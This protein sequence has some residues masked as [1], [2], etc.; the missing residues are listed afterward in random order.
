[1]GCPRSGTT[2]LQLMLHAHPRIAVPPEN[3]FMLPAYSKRRLLGDLREP[4]NKRKLAAQIIGGKG[5]ASTQF[6]DL[7]LDPGEITDAIVAAP[8]TVGSALGTVFRAYAARF[9]KPRWGDKRPAYHH[10]LPFLRRMFPDAQFV[11][12]VRD[13]RACV[14]SL[15]RM[16]WWE[17]DMYTAVAEWAVAFDNCQRFAKRLPADSFHQIKYEELVTDPAGELKRLCAFLGEDYDDAMAQPKQVAKVAVPKHKTWHV[18]TADDVSTDQ[19][20][21]WKEQLE[22]WEISLCETA[23]GRRLR[24]YGYQLSDAPRAGTRHLSEYTKRHARWRYNQERRLLAD[25]YRS[26]TEREPVADQVND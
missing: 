24:S 19:V 4:E 16:P 2:M 6:K 5:K 15:K 7:G 17:Y 18:A 3:R 21:K 14:A 22:P 11:Q 23:L 1:M 12:V 25:R 26:F 20:E 8:P 13:G 9:D 10:Y